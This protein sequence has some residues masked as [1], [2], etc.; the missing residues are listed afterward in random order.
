MTTARLVAALALAAAACGA[1]A[2]QLYQWTDENGR[3]HVTDTPPPASAKEKRV[4]K[5]AGAAAKA[6][7]AK[8]AAAAPHAL[9]LAMKQHPVTLY[10][11]PNC[12]EP[13]GLARDM[14]NQRGV[15]FREVQVWA[16][17]GN[18][19]LKRL[20]GR[21]QVPTLK[22]GAIVY[23]GFE[24]SAYDGMLDS[25]GYPSVGVLPA[26]AQAVPGRP[27]GYIPPEEREKPNA[28]A[29]TPEPAASGPYA[30]GAS[31]KRAQKK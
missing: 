7:S 26:R 2:Q 8:P 27:E 17:E 3:V 10:T 21:N 24:R 14:L 12:T 16:K 4:V 23:S 5:P 19:E 15:P 1:A 9:D 11:S 20:S 31:S 29:A 18:D 30:P 22:V 25:A 28:E 6:A 13:C